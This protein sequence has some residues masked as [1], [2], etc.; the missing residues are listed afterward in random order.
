MRTGLEADGR[1]E[2]AVA[3]RGHGLSEDARARLFD[4]F[5]TTKPG[6][7]GLGLSI[8][9][10]IVESHGG[11]LWATDHPGG[12]TVVRFVLPAAEEKVNAG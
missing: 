1:V 9:R 12:G 6:G 11:H 8:C 7:M 3:D 2:I 10:T 5:F 4:P